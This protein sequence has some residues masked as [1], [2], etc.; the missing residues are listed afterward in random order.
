MSHV[1]PAR[2]RT[3]AAAP[4]VTLIA[5]WG[6]WAACG[7]P[8]PAGDDTIQVAS[9]AGWRLSGPEAASFTAATDRAVSH[10]GAASGRLEATG[11]DVVGAATLMQS[12]PAGPYRGKRV[13]FSAAVRTERVARWAGLWMRIDRPRGRDA[14]DNM[15]DRAVH[16][17]TGWTRRAVVLDVADDA[18][19]I[20]FGLVQ[21][22]PGVSRIDDAALEVVGAEVA[23]SDID[24]R[25]RALVNPG[26]EVGGDAPVGWLAS[27]W[28]IDDVQVGLDRGVRHGGAAS[29]RIRSRVVRPRGTAMLLQSLRADDARG[30]RLR[31]VAWVRGA[32]VDSGSLLVQVMA[33]DSGLGSEGISRA[34][35]DLT[36]TFDWRRCELVFDVPARADTIHVSPSLEGR[37]TLWVDDLVLDQVASDVPV[38]WVDQRPNG[39]TNGDFE[40]TGGEVEG[41][42]L[43]GGARGHYHAS[44]DSTVAHGGRAIEQV[45]RAVPLESGDAPS[46]TVE[47]G[48][49]E[50]GT[51]LPTGWFMSGGAS[52]D[53]EVAI[54]RVG[55]AA[56]AASARLR[57][58]SRRRAATA[59]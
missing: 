24:R 36:G 43:S 3:A 14:F 17:T 31:L 53:F 50:H 52:D 21:D 39:P 12:I 44:V 59:P 34:A 49:L 48:G 29:G 8:A 19:T 42:F 9:P 16:G 46:G 10:G 18:D 37:G 4:L 38:S 5:A 7:P 6:A 47:N 22:G 55:R 20:E 57:P 35:C 23:P 51:D 26:F 45:S 28:G 32:A 27:G 2:S 33:V 15:Q 54:D 25:P 41:W 40:A 56:G 30:R 1:H 58:G 11:L 13:R